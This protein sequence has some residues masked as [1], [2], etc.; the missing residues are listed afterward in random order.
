VG[1]KTAETKPLSPAEQLRLGELSSEFINLL[2]NYRGCRL[3]LGRI[4]GELKPL[5]V[6]V[7]RHGGWSRFITSQGLAVRTVDKWIEDYGVDI[8]IREPAGKKGVKRKTPQAKRNVAD[9]ATFP[10]PHVDLSGKPFSDGKEIVEAV[11]V[12]G[13]AAERTQFMEALKEIGPE[14]APEFMMEGLLRE[15]HARREG[16]SQTVLTPIPT[17]DGKPSRLLSLRD[18]EPL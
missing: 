15:F 18:E 10:E 3:E 1:K 2:P 7:G 13:T 9:S 16:E 17:P 6:K 12:L 8:G 11:F 4:A 5:Y 14:K